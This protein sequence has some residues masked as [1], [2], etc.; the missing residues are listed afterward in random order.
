MLALLGAAGPHFVVVG[1]DQPEQLAGSEVAP[2][3]LAANGELQRVGLVLEAVDKGG[4]AGDAHLLGGFAAGVTVYQD[5]GVVA[6]PNVDG[7]RRV[8][9]VC[10]HLR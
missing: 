1:T 3:G 10:R 8:E 6:L 9:P 4:Q 2:L 5:E 7:V